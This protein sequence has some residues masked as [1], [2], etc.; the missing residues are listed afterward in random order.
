MKKIIGGDALLDAYFILEKAKIG[1]KMKIADFG[2]GSLGHFLFPAAS[3]VGK[4]GRVYA[5]DILKTSLETI[6]R[7]AKVENYQNIQTVWSDL[8]IFNATKIETGSIDVGLLINTLYHSRKRVDMLR[9]CIRMIKKGGKL[10]VVEWS[11]MAL[12]F[13]PSPEARVKKELLENVAGRLG[14]HLEA[15]FE[16]GHYHYGLVFIKL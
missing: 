11:N 3:I 9:E 12:P 5:V 8:E 16:A 10:I 14:L 13:G 1:D 2:C 7:R 4:N 15:E 6:V